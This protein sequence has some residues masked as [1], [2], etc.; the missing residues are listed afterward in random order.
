MSSN[1]I[2]DRQALSWVLIKSKI[3]RN[4]SSFIVIKFS[5]T[6]QNSLGK[7]SYSFTK[8]REAKE[9]ERVPLHLI[10]NLEY[11]CDEWNLSFAVLKK[12]MIIMT[13]WAWRSFSSFHFVNMMFDTWCNYSDVICT[14]NH[15]FQ[16]YKK[17]QGLEMRESWYVAYFKK[18]EEKLLSL[19][20]QLEELK[21][22]YITQPG[23]MNVARPKG[24]L[25]RT[26]NGLR[27]KSIWRTRSGN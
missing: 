22:L 6:G 17:S 14:R 2:Q 9:L 18:Q 25:A 27:S 26:R 10:R 16:I 13:P 23:L 4:E 11:P 8:Y 12:K 21:S 20:E 15:R 1:K 19:I 24:G 3:G 5:S 7:K